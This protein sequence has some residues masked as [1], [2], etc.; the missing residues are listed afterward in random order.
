MCISDFKT[1][2]MDKLVGKFERF[3]RL[4]C[5]TSLVLRSTKKKNPFLVAGVVPLFCVPLMCTVYC[6]TW[7]HGYIVVF[8]K[9]EGTKST[10]KSEALKVKVDMH[11]F[12]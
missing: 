8:K 4:P 7:K 6:F 2:T 1:I 9:S 3:H 12:T 10:F 5:V 11:L